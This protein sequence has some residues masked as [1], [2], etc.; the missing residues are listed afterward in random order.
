MPLGRGALSAMSETERYS[1][2]NRG[3]W[4]HYRQLP[5]RGSIRPCLRKTGEKGGRW[6]AVLHEGKA[7]DEDVVR[8]RGVGME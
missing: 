4:R 2:G 6:R 5:G 3:H 7:S 1:V 8:H